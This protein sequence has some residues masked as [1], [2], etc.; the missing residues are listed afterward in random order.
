[1]EP[2]YKTTVAKMIEHTEKKIDELT[3]IM[4]SALLDLSIKKLSLIGYY[5]VCDENRT[6]LTQYKENLDY[7]SGC[8]AE[9]EVSLMHFEWEIYFKGVLRQ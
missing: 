6:A 9:E 3:G 4:S 8:N 1:M 7:L 2:K 5:A